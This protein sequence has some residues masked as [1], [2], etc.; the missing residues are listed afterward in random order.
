MRTSGRSISFVFFILF[1]SLLF[2]CSSSRAEVDLSAAGVS[3]ELP[4]S[5][6]TPFI[7]TIGL[8]ADHR[9]YEPATPLGIIPGVNFG[10][11]ATIAKV[12]PTEGD[13][14][15]VLGALPILPV[16]RLHVHKGITGF[17]DVGLSAIYYKGYKGVGPIRVYGGDVKLALYQPEEG[18]TA[19]ARL[20]YTSSKIWI[21]STQTIT[22]QF[23]FSRQMSFADPYFGFGY[24]YATGKVDL[25]LSVLGQSLSITGKGKAQGAIAFTGVQF[26]GLG[27]MFTIEGT[28]STVG[29]HT[30][31]TKF[32]L[33]F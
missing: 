31:G 8:G 17:L 21:I 23:V 22:P 13:T 24:Q 16:A 20:C 29:V 19:A 33:A 32:G 6:V 1:G 4:S 7:K 9:P 12:A 10:I 5:V 14:G 26:K 3:T 18:L 2:I 30:L 25:P 15:G 28:Y 11:E 27:L